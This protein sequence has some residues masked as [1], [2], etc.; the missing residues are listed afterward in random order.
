MKFPLL[1]RSSRRNHTKLFIHLGSNPSPPSEI[2]SKKLRRFS[3]NL[4]RFW[5][6][7]RRFLRNVGDF[8]VFVRDLFPYSPTAHEPPAQEGKIKLRIYR[9]GSGENIGHLK[10]NL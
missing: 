6:N 2:S 7:L 8:F 4:Q 1:P 10:I 3:E 5:K 9:T